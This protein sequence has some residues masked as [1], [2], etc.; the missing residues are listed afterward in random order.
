V[1]TL[2]TLLLT[3]AAAALLAAAA[4]AEAKFVHFTSP[5]G[6]IDCLGDTARPSWV[7]C[8][9][10]KANWPRKPR[11]PAACDNDWFP[12]QVELQ[13]RRVRVGACRGDVGPMC[14]PRGSGM[15][16]ARLPYGRAVNIGTIRCT[17]TTAG[18]TC[19]QR[20]A[21]R[22]GFRVARQGYVRYRS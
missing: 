12:T 13:A 1:K 4:P 16:C 21:P 20:S 5:S 14:G 3:A 6:N 7:Q 22:V 9:V 11:R 17:S 15:G 8:W 2:R 19:R 18:V 10:Q